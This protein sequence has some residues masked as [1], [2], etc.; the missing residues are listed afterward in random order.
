MTSAF[1]IMLGER[2]EGYLA[3]RRSL[4]YSLKKQAAILRELVR[5]V[6]AQELEGPLSRGHSRPAGLS[7]PHCGGQ[8]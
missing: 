4:G 3:L 7:A 8:A 5:Y 2:V 1:A 6:A